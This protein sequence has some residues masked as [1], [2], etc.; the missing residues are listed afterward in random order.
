VSAD[1]ATTSTT[2]VWV[3]PEP[4]DGPQSRALSSWAR[5][6]GAALEP[7]AKG[8]AASLA[9][10]PRDAD[11]VERLLD[12][13]RDAIAARDAE[14]VDRALGLAE[15]TL[16]AHP[17]LPQGAWLMAEVER[18]RSAR[19]RRV[20]PIDEAAAD[21]AWA[22]AEA[23]DGGRVPGVGEKA[24]AAHGAAA[25]LV[26]EA[27]EG[28]TVLLDG[29]AIGP[30]PRATREG[31][32]ALVV[33]W[34][35]AP[36]WASWIDVPPGTTTVRPS[37]PAP[38][39]CSATDVAHVRVAAGTV[40]ASHVRCGTWAAAMPGPSADA[41]LVALCEPGR[42]GPLLEWKA[43]SWAWT[44][45]TQPERAARGWPTWATWGLVGAG[46]VV[47]TGVVVLAT[48]ALRSSPSETRFVSGGVKSQ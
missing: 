8:Q 3:A 15:A 37:A 44:P 17:E 5:A 14:G 9:V 32:H 6:H 11:E 46:A 25:T 41:V 42:C 48:G 47:A 29:E 19:W 31:S 30:G 38:A 22:R 20:P 26:V 13:A 33:A 21:R 12:R 2:L 40:E 4:P 23:I 39:P 28:A 10:D 24:G 1:A 34:D 18:A 36:A 27:P 7:P 45:P 43:E 35:G 16:R